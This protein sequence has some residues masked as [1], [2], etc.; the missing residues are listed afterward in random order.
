MKYV[1]SVKHLCIVSMLAIFVSCNSEEKPAEEAKKEPGIKTENI[2]YSSDSV[3]M[4]GFIAYDSSVTTKRPI[5]MVI[6]EWWGLNDYTKQ[7]ARQLAELG[8]VAFA[9]DIYGNG[10]TAEN[11]KDAESLAMPF[12]MNPEMAKTRFDAALAKAKQLSQGDSEKIASIGYCFGGGLSI[13]M[14]RMGSDLDG[15]VSFHGNLSLGPNDKNLLKSK[16]LVCH[17]AADPLVPQAEVDQFKKSM[18][19][20]GADY[21]FKS[22]PGAL[23]A[24]TNPDATA[25]G[26]K[27]NMP[28][29]YDAKADSASWNDMKTFFSRVF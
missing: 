5:V 28:V 7:R 15:V 19:S 12:Y 24:F 26:Q 23:H 11:P 8:Y 13:A 6:H 25:I 17:G 27:F 22:Y 4:N 29:A 16:I 2:S 9:V 20:I 18:D 3:T 21:T 10:K 14:A 1:N